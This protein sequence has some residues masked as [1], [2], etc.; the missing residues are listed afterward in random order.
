MSD[1]SRVDIK[2]MMELTEQRVE[3]FAVA[4]LT[5]EHREHLGASIIGHDCARYIWFVFRWVRM[6]AFSGRQLRLFNRGNREEAW[7]I[8]LLRGSGWTITDTDPRTGKQ[9]RIVGSGDHYGGSLDSV[10]IPPE[11]FPYRQPMLVEYKTHNDSSFRKLKKDGVVISKPQHYAQMCAYGREYGFEYAM[12]CAVDKDDDALHFEFVKLDYRHADDLSRKADEI[13]L[14]R[15]PPQPIALQP[16]HY[17][18]KFCPFTGI[19]FRHEAVD[20]NCR[21]CL[22]SRPADGAQWFCEVHQQNIPKDFIPIGCDKHV[23]IM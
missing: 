14:S 8:H 12:Y 1:L 16:E 3:Q 11:D 15:T 4:S 13:I 18:C 6:S 21:S 22:Y 23:G 5:N 19:C 17:D 9:I 7:F 20:K 10:G 2:A